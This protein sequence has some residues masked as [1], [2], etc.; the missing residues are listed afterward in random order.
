MK[1][2]IKFDY[3]KE[4]RGHQETRFKTGPHKNK[5]DKRKKNKEQQEIREQKEE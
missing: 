1:E 3:T 2:K 4:E 5:K